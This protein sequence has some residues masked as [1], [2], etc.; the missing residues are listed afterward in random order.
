MIKSMFDLK[1]FFHQI[2]CPKY[3]SIEMQGLILEKAPREAIILKNFSKNVSTI[4][5]N[6]FIIMLCLCSIDCRGP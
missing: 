1:I 3:N 6:E 4:F 2:F 5:F